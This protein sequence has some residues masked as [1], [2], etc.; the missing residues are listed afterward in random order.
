MN[1]LADAE[2]LRRERDGEAA[3]RKFAEREREEY[4]ADAEAL[5]E[6]LR[7]IRDTPYVSDVRLREIAA[8]ALAEQER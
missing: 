2:A 5:R 6:A 7:E 3:A 1:A 4:A 8:T